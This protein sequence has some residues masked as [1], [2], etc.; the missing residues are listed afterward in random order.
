MHITEA[1]ARS[2]PFMLFFSPPYV[3]IHVSRKCITTSKQGNEIV[4]ASYE[5]FP[6]YGKPDHAGRKHSAQTGG[7]RCSNKLFWTEEEEVDDISVR[8]FTDGAKPTIT[9]M[10]RKQLVIL[11]S[12]LGHKRLL[13]KFFT[14]VLGVFKHLQKVEN[15]TL[16]YDCVDSMG[17]CVPNP[18]GLWPAPGSKPCPYWTVTCPLSLSL[19]KIEAR[20]LEV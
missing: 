10:L 19:G 3:R 18:S 12:K 16:V 20:G 11:G 4:D 17:E 2:S 15:L 13:F 1:S 5:G 7:R 6:N 8:V 9:A 14:L